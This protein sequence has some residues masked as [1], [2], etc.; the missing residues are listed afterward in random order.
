MPI[1]DHSPIG[2]GIAS[3]PSFRHYHHDTE[4]PISS[5]SQSSSSSSR[6][7]P[8]D[9]P[10]DMDNKYELEDYIYE[11]ECRNG[12][13]HPETREE[14]EEADVYSRLAQ[15]EKDLILA[16]ELGKALLERNEVLVGQNERLAED[17]SQKLEVSS[18]SLL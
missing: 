1:T 6:S 13:I 4:G 14:P 15:K 11:M 5:S 18:I 16:A 7:N 9:M 12:T 17:Y 2:G 10:S 3:N 8:G